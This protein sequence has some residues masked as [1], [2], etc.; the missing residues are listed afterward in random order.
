MAKEEARPRHTSKKLLTLAS[1]LGGNGDP[2]AGWKM[3]FPEAIKENAPHM[4]GTIGKIAEAVTAK[5]AR[6]RNRLHNIAR[7]RQQACRQPRRR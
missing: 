1:A 7:Y 4:L 5:Q 3:A 2:D 6:S